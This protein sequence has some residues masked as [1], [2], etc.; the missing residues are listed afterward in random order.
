MKTSNKKNTIFGVLGRRAS[1][2]LVLGL[3]GLLVTFTSCSSDDDARID[4]DDLAGLMAM[5]MIVDQ[6]AVGVSLSGS[7]VGNFPFR[8]YTGGYVNIFPGNRSADAFS[9]YNRNTLATISFTYEPGKYYSL[10]MIGLKENYENIVVEDNLNDLK[11]EEGMAYI[12][13]INGIAT[14]K[15]PELTVS[16]KE[17][18]FSEE[19]VYGEVSS[20]EKIPAGELIFNLTDGDEIDAERTVKLEEGRVYTFLLVGNP[21]NRD[22]TK[23]VQIRYIENGWLTEDIDSEKAAAILKQK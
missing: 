19:A 18:L 12:R 22:G 16:A 11:S 3:L 9:V 17:E 20:F 15:N 23:E 10:F 13:Y 6:E 1:K 5:N 7:H 21:D 8:G 2:I 4:P 14:D